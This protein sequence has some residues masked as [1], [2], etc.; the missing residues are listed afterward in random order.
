MFN[1]LSAPTLFLSTVDGA[2]NNFLPH[3]EHGQDQLFQDKESQEHLLQDTGKY[4]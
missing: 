4:Y 1:I 3:D 2:G